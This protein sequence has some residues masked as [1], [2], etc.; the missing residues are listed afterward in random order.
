MI[1]SVYYVVSGNSVLSKEILT[2]HVQKMGEMSFHLVHNWFSEKPFR[3]KTKYCSQFDTE[4]NAYC[5]RQNAFY[6]RGFSVPRVLRCPAGIDRR[7]YVNLDFRRN[8]GL[9]DTLGLNPML[10]EMNLDYL[11]LLYCEIQKYEVMTT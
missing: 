8:L 3:P 9:I 11:K 6:L 10:Y 5:V 2:D 4:I 7:C 1:T